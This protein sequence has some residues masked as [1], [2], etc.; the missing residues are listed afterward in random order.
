DAGCGCGRELQRVERLVP[1]AEGVGIDLAAGM[2]NAAHRDAVAHGIRNVAFVQSDVGDLPAEFTGQF[3]VVYNCLAHHHYPEPQRASRSILR[4]LRGAGVY[5]IVDPGP[6]WFNAISSGLARWGDPGWIRFH[7]PEE[8]SVLL[9]D[10]G[11]ARI[12]SVE[13]LP[14]F[15]LTVAQA[16]D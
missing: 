10:S 7:S 13:L 14:G 6:A 5:C 11:F 2:V 3:D 12:G 16:P 15:N 4:A 1:N 8:F 9:R